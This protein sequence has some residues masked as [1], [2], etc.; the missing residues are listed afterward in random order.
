[1]FRVV[2]NP[3]LDVDQFINQSENKLV[4]LVSTTK[5]CGSRLIC[6]LRLNFEALLGICIYFGNFWVGHVKG[7]V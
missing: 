6:E 2:V 1:M 5:S 3:N 4:H 7:Y